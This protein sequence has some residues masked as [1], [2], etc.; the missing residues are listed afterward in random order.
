M[1]VCG[2]KWAWSW[3]LFSPQSGSI[4]P[5][6]ETS[7]STFKPSSAELAYCI[8]LGDWWRAVQ[9]QKEKKQQ[10]SGETIHDL[11]EIYASGRVERMHRLIADASPTAPPNGFFD[12]TVEVRSN[13]TP[14][15]EHKLT[16]VLPDPAHSF[17]RQWRLECLHDGLYQQ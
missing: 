3:A 6:G 10:E 9:E 1:G 13:T 16:H 2:S 17:K 15:H 4:T 12:C 5:A 7:R 11:T 14:Y 8:K